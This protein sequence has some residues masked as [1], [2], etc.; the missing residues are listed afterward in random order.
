M[1]G[2]G[3]VLA[4]G[5]VAACGGSG[6]AAQKAQP[7]DVK[8][9]T[10]QTRTT[11]PQRVPEGNRSN[12]LVGPAL[13]R[14]RRAA[15]SACRKVG[16]PPALAATS[17]SP[18]ARGKEVAVELERLK[19][20]ERALAKLRPPQRVEDEFKSYD[21]V[22]AY[23][24]RIDMQIVRAGRYGDGKSVTIGMQQNRANRTARNESARK[25]GLAR[26]LRDASA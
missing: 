13:L 22:L 10:T 3:S 21:R 26:C 20:L 14:F 5:A 8:S 1:A 17:P 11:P 23:Q 12:P 24:I 9:A 15:A 16:R 25:L 7:D 19:R 18:E 4:S 6:G 2:I